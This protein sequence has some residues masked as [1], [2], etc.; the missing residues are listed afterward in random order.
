MADDPTFYAPLQYQ[1]LWMWLGIVLIVVVAGWYAWLFRPQ[2]KRLPAGTEAKLPDVETLRSHCLAAIE[3]TARD[4]DA[5][6]VPEREAHQRLSFLVREFAGAA[7]GLPVTSMTLDELRRE[8]L[9]GLAEGIAGIYPSE[10]SAA[11]IMPVQ[12]SAEI[13]RRVVQSWN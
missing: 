10:F 11:N 12:N 5:G 4:A 7:T 3:T 9:D 13:A 1:S 2:R 6:R 8:G